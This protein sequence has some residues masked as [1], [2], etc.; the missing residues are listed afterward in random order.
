MRTD[1]NSLLSISAPS[2]AKKA[3]INRVPERNGTAFSDDFSRA[4]EAFSPKKDSHDQPS[5]ISEARTKSASHDQNTVME[6]RRSRNEGQQKA[7]SEL[8]TQNAKKDGQQTLSSSSKTTD[9]SNK[10]AVKNDESFGSDGE[11]GGKNLQL[12]GE[13]SPKQTTDVNQ[14]KVKQTVIDASQVAGAVK[15]AAVDSTQSQLLSTEIEQ[16]SVNASGVTANVV[17]GQANNELQLAQQAVDVVTGDSSLQSVSQHRENVVQVMLDGQLIGKPSADLSLTEEQLES[18]NADQI[19]ALQAQS[20]LSLKMEKEGVANTELSP[21]LI[22]SLS[23][24]TGLTE[25][26]KAALTL[27]TVQATTQIDEIQQQVKPTA[28]A[29]AVSAG[30]AVSAD[31]A[32]AAVDGQLSW[33]LDQMTSSS[34]QTNQDGLTAGMLADQ[35]AKDNAKQALLAGAGLAMTANKLNGE[36]TGSAATEMLDGVDLETIDMMP[37]EPIEL[38][39]KEHEAMLSKMAG[40]NPLPDDVAMFNSSLN[41][42]QLGRVMGAAGVA[43][44]LA[45]PN[46]AAMNMAMSVPPGHPNW[47]AEMGQKVA[48]IAREGGHTAHIRLDPPELGSLTVKVSVDNDANTQ[49]NFVAATSQA[50]DLLEGQMGRLRDMLAQQGMDLSRAEVDVS[51]QDASGAQKDPR[52]ATLVAS[53]DAALDEQG[54]EEMSTAMMSYVSP[55]GVDYYA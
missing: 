13:A 37:N 32:E 23:G 25:E 52:Q 8:A 24:E 14:E 27:A 38:R 9:D 29:A 7:S 44:Q 43:S 33:V 5:N 16:A 54:E 2:T 17:Q 15:Q 3:P 55:T 42:Q 48:W 26:Q 19:A 39:K 31:S 46:Q 53:N 50:R 45:T 11:N 18:L 1:S 47:A 30:M 4:K 10:V 35:A 36:L 28:V 21:E 34:K 40:Q 20:A 22:A 51:Q 6:A 12:S 49:I 41:Q